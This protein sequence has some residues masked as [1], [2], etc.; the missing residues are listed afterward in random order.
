MSEAQG[1]VTKKNG[2]GIAN[3]RLSRDTEIGQSE[4]QS[5]LHSAGGRVLPKDRGEGCYEQQA[6]REYSGRWKMM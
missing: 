4:L 5:A 1:T 2:G 3:D 6:R